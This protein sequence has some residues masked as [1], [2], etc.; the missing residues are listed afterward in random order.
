[1]YLGSARG[2]IVLQLR[3]RYELIRHAI[4]RGPDGAPD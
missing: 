1:M 2:T 4:Q 3:K